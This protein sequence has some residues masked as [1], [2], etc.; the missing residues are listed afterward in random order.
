[1]VPSV[2]ERAL[3]SAEEV[4]GQLTLLRFQVLDSTFLIRGASPHCWLSRPPSTRQLYLSSQGRLTFCDLG[5]QSPPPGP[6]HT[7]GNEP[8]EGQ[9]GPVSQVTPQLGPDIC[10]NHVGDFLRWLRG[11]QQGVPGKPEAGG[12]HK[13]HGL[14]GPS[15]GCL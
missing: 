13:G 8:Q 15:S 7:V 1:M 3:S 14:C 5:T 6:Q 10:Y 9:A 4:K 11:L 12:P 2:S